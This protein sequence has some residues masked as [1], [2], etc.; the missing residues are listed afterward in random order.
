MGAWIGLKTPLPQ[1][2]LQSRANMK[3]GGFNGVQFVEGGMAAVSCPPDGSPCFYIGEGQEIRLEGFELMG[4]GSAVVV[5][6][7]SVVQFDHV[8]FIA[9]H[10]V[11]GVDTSPAGCSGCNVILGSRNA[12]LVIVNSYWITLSHCSFQFYPDY[13]QDGTVTSAAEKGQRPSVILRGETPAP[14]DSDQQTN[15]VYLV[16]FEH[17]VF[18]GGGVQYQQTGRGDQWPGFISLEWSVLEV[19]ATP[20]LDL[21]AAP[22][23]T[24]DWRTSLP[25]DERRLTD[26]VG[27]HSV[28]TAARFL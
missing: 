17:S 23:A 9:T 24:L 21:Q 27:L 1:V 12:P 18:S 8:A 22:N 20:L 19:S 6:T 15:T 3:G 26:F 7:A 4:R 5:H 25:P 11:E 16:H 14:G 13:R 10:D 2:T 28:T